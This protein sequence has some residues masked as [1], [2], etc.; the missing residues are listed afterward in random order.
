MCL[1]G[2][3]NLCIN[4]A[5]PGH[6]IFGGY[7]EYIVRPQNAVLRIPENIGYE[8]AAA[9]MWSYTTPLNCATRRA[10]V[11]PG[12]TVLITGASSGIALACSQLAKLFGAKT[13]STTTKI[14][15]A[16][17]LRALGYDHVMD[18]KDERTPER[19]K[20]LTQGLGVDAVWDCVGGS[21]SLQ[22]SIKCVRL[23]GSVAVLGVPVSEEGFDLQLNSLGFI[24]PELNLVGVRGAGRRDQQLC[25]ELLKEEKISP[26]IDRTFPLSDAAEAHAYLE[27]QKQIGKILL[28]P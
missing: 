27:S 5:Y 20:D 9:T 3:D 15:R 19:I 10:P 14:Y 17:K 25:L 23:G 16:D 21:E 11:G 4:T 6:Q 22:F 26:V 1:R 2:H 18:Y 8:M 12:D 13:I 24:F 28:I 7:A